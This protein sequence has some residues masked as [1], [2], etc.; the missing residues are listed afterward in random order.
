MGNETSKSMGRRLAD[1]RFKERWFV[2]EGMD[3]GAG[4]DP[5]TDRH[6][7][8]ITHL[9][10][11]DTRDGDAM[12]LHSIPDERFDFVYSSHCLEHVIDARVAIVNWWRVL[13]PGGHLIVVVPD[14]DLYERGVWPPNK[15]ATHHWS[16][17][18]WKRESWSPKSINVLDMVANLDPPAQFLKVES[19]DWPFDYGNPE[20]QSGGDA[21]VGIEFVARKMTNRDIALKGRYY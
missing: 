1:P 16:F 5:L 12:Y 10:E 4:P 3:I 20:D 15:N 13:R 19:L 7:P 11:W 14:E 2:G 17:T 21:P 8:G 18:I 6:F 9:R